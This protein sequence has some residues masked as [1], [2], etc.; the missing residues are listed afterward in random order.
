MFIHPKKVCMSYWQHFK[1]SMYISYLLGRGC[2][3]AIGHAI[4]PDK[5]T[6][7]TS[8]LNK[9]IGDLLDNSGCKS[10]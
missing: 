5:L 6:K 8:D 1:F 7:S 9:K 3:S 4:Y 10:K 2:L